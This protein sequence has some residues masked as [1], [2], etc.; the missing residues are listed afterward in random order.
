[1]DDHESI[2]CHLLMDESLFPNLTSLLIEAC[3]KISILI[4][5]S[6]LGSLEHLEKL[7]VRNCKNMQEIVSLEESSK[8]IVFNGL[9]HLTLE[10]LPNLKA[11]CLSSCDFFFPSLGEMEIKDC[12]N[13]E[14]FSLGFSTTPKLGDVRMKQSSLNIR[15]NIQKTDI[16]DIVRGFKAFVCLILQS[17]SF[18]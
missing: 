1:V 17:L 15:G 7:E 6:S 5:H 4:S 11:F 9:K 2:R 8:K 14:V 12:P 18:S 10:N 13:M 16:N 3:N